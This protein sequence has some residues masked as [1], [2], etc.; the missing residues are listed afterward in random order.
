EIGALLANPI[1]RR[2]LSLGIDRAA[3]NESFMLGTGRPSAVAPI[4]QNRYFPGQ[5]WAGRWATLDIQESN[6]LLD[7]LGLI[8]RD[9]AGLRLRKDRRGPLQLI[10]ETFI[11][12]FDYAAVAEMIRDQWRRIGIDLQVQIVH[13]SLFMQRSLA[14]TVQLTLQATAGED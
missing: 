5:A 1:F 3:I 8:E 13:D 6:R 10:C 2:A 11:A 4:P 12:N 14:G 7:S 9:A